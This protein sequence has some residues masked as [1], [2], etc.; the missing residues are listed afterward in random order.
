MVALAMVLQRCT[1]C[2]VMPLGVLC[3]VVQELHK[4]LTPLIE[5]G[6]QFYLEM[7]DMVKRDPVV[8]ASAQRASSPTPRAEEQMYLPPASQPLWSQRR[9]YSPRSWPWCQG[10]DHQHHLALPFHGWMSPNHLL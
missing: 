4:F 7:L 2:S 5:S 1:I 9:L 10:E 3:G 8:P 6:D